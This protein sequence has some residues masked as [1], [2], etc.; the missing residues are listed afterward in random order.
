MRVR[1]H[2]LKVV[3][4]VQFVP[5]NSKFLSLSFPF[6]PLL[7]DSVSLRRQ[8]RPSVLQVLGYLTE[9]QPCM[10][11]SKISF[12]SVCLLVQLILKLSSVIRFEDVTKKHK[13][14][15]MNLSH[16]IL[17]MTMNDMSGKHF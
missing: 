17:Q 4:N 6:F 14:L 2:A 15:N 5:I 7:R 10:R 3:F 12:D 16:V 1:F 13:M 9:S 11:V 8:Q